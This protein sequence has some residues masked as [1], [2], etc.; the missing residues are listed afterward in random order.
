MLRADIKI[1]LE[2]EG[3]L[4]TKST[5]P[6]EY[7]MDAVVARNSDGVPYIPGTLLTGKVREALEQLNECSEGVDWF[8]SE[9]PAWL[10]TKSNRAVPQ[11]KRLLL[12]DFLLAQEAGNGVRTRIKIDPDRGAAIKGAQLLV[13]EPFA[14]GE[15]LFFTGRLTLFVQN[16]G[17]LSV[18]DEESLQSIVRHVEAAL[19]W[20]SQLGGY[21]T[22]GYGRL[23]KVTMDKPVQRLIRSPQSCPQTPGSLDV[24]IRPEAPFCIARK[25][26]TDNN[27]FESDTIIPGGAIIGAISTTW[28]KL[29]GDYSVGSVADIDDNERTDLRDDFNQIRITHALPSGVGLVRPVV[30]PLT[31]VKVDTKGCRPYYDVARLP[32]PCLIHGQAPAFAIDWKDFADV[33]KDFGWPSLHRELRVRTAIDR[34]TLRSKEAELFAYEMVVPGNT[35]W[36]ARID[37]DEEKVKNPS[38]VGGQLASLLEHG[39]AGLGKT[40]TPADIRILPA[41]SVKPMLPSNPEPRDGLWIITLQTPTL[42][43]DPEPLIESGTRT[44]TLA[45]YRQAWDDLSEGAL[46]LIRHFSRQSLAGGN[47]LFNRFQKGLDTNGAPKNYY[48]WLLTDAGSVFVLEAASGREAEAKKLVKQWLAHGLDLPPWA[49]AR[50]ARKVKDGATLPGDHWRSCPYIRQNGYGEIAVNLETHWSHCPG[51]GEFE[52]I[53]WIGEEKQQ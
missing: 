37:L 31:L 30:F 1:C 46:H 11:P 23:Q 14:I 21:R 29:A 17:S 6:G 20:I 47:Y 39:I 50:Y 53:D 42:L 43:C 7:G 26:R 9:S 19:H 28:K 40:K 3:P 24:L 10:G 51:E 18:Q 15:P 49:V 33:E 32:G 8:N 34:K 27:L 4:L 22:I 38:A 2:I 36:Y 12:S 41:E 48:P 52:T 16:E 45:A 25:P 5:A 44:R 35:G 13:D